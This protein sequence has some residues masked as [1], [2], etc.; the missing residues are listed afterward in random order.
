MQ[1]NECQEAQRDFA[2]LGLSGLR[3][4]ARRNPVMLPPFSPQAGT[5][6]RDLRDDWANPP[7]LLDLRIKRDLATVEPEPAISCQ[8][9]SCGL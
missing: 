6:Q 5:N 3:Y 2:G 7:C 9:C 8:E 4:A 1:Y